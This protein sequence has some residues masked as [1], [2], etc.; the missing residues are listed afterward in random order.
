MTT[1]SPEQQ[2]SERH[3]KPHHH[4]GGHK[5]RRHDHGNHNPPLRRSAAELVKQPPRG[6]TVE[7]IELEQDKDA[8]KRTR[9][10]VLASDNGWRFLLFMSI[11]VP[12]QMSTE[13][14]PITVIDDLDILPANIVESAIEVNLLTDDVLLSLAGHV[15]EFREKQKHVVPQHKRPLVQRPFEEKLALRKEEEEDMAKKTAAAKAAANHNNSKSKAQHTE[16]KPVARPQ[17]RGRAYRDAWWWAAA[18]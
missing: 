8:R 9:L 7:V 15:A 10:M 11:R 12:K 17:P 5:D 4:H 6:Y 3:Q 1:T 14:G 13:G 2:K 16:S 18:C